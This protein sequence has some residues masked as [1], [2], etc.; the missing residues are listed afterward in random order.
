[1]VN[2]TEADPRSANGVAGDEVGLQID[3]AEPL[4]LTAVRAVEAV[5]AK[6]EAREATSGGQNGGTGA[7]TSPGA[8]H[9]TG[10]VTIRVSGAPDGAWT[11]DA[12]V[13]LVTKWERALRRLERLG[14]PTVAIA[15]G[16]IGGLALDV[17]LTTDFRIAAPST[18][19]LVSVDAGATWPGM[20]TYRLA[21]QAGIAPI[22]R[23]VLFGHPVGAT[24]AVALGLVHEVAED[25]AQALSAVTRTVATL[26]GK[27]LAIRRQLIHDAST[28]SFE[29]ALG[30]HLAACDRTLRQA[31]TAGA[32]P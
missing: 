29:V 15:S 7:R 5:C 8:G 20:A 27:E 26:S 17:L 25:P 32:A 30:A 13:A 3:G 10:I 14:A 11:R 1:M 9:G 16:D 12:N 23:M 28:T 22:R 31:A 24:E 19:L 4:S 2:A 18:R 6:V 21:A